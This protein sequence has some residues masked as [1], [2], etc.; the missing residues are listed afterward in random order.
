MKRATRFRIQ[1]G[2]KILL[3]DMD[4]NPVDVLKL[5]GLPADLFSRPGASMSTAEYFALWRGV[6]M[7]AGQRELPILL[8]EA[9]S[10]EAF[11][12]ALFAALCSPNLNM[13]L[14]RL[15]EFK[16]LIGPMNLAVD[17]TNTSTTVAIDC[18]GYKAEIPSSLGAM[19]M[20]FFTQLAR[21]AT[22][23][24][25]VPAQVQFI[26]AP[27]DPAP[28]TRYFGMQVQVGGCYQI[29]FTAEDAQRPFLTENSALWDFF[30]PDLKLRLSDLESEAD[31]AQRVKSA[32][33][34]MLPRGESSIEE[35]ARQLAMSKRTLQR[36]LG[37]QGANFQDIL[38]QTRKELAQHYL[39][40]SMLPPGEISFLLGFQD[41][42]SFTRAFSNWTGQTPI[43]YRG[44]AIHP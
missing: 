7:A 32:L 36:R 27:V 20:V 31:T 23:A 43:Q 8:G 19:E 38:K 22:R 33:L 16:R 40:N 41:T 21:L 29:S 34:E 42:N 1:P 9:I 11:D 35:T 10:V 39:A 15:H 37:C 13:A 17:I 44:A 3:T 2:W 6:E 25:I 12:P 24:H 18:V 5:G 26:H 14:S 28:Y 4:I 30:E